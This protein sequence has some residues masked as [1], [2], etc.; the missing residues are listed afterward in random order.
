MYVCADARDC[1][2]LDAINVRLQRCLVLCLLVACVQVQQEDREASS[3]A[4]RVLLRAVLLGKLQSNVTMLEE[5]LRYDW[6]TYALLP[7]SAK[8]GEPTNGA[9]DEAGL[10]AMDVSDLCDSERALMDDKFFKKA[11][12]ER[13]ARP[14]NQQLL[15]AAMP[16]RPATLRLCCALRTAAS[17]HAY[18]HTCSHADALTH[19]RAR[20]LP[21]RPAHASRRHAPEMIASFS[22]IR[23]IVLREELRYMIGTFVTIVHGS[24][25]AQTTPLFP[26]RPPPL[27]Y[28]PFPAVPSYRLPA[29]RSEH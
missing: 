11:M 22:E 25:L 20:A 24:T 3:A 17:Q 15:S 13:Y 21:C 27:R 16:L 10:S 19:T 9:Y 12:L 6:G 26:Y 28:S 1:R 7:D 29:H 8:L 14:R 5:F 2:T 23:P 4:F 18:V